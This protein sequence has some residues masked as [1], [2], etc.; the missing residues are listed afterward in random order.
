MKENPRAV[1][2]D[3]FKERLERAKLAVIAEYKGLTVK[4]LETFRR[5]LR[6]KGA[7]LRIIK[8]T[9][10]RRALANANLPDCEDMLKGQVAFVLGYE[11]AVSG[12]QAIK[13]F[14]RLH[15]EFKVLGG[16]FEG[17]AVGADVINQLAS[18]P[19]KDQ[20][21]ANLLM[22]LQGPQRRFMSLLKAVPRELVGTLEALAK[23]KEESAPAQEE[24]TG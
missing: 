22:L 4:E 24:A 8:N 19:N 23:N 14:V 15:K 21:R 6:E 10:A 17:Q 1:L 11:D 3:N 20:L 16:I 2:V 7:Q 5:D 9:L 18:L 13:G 12:P